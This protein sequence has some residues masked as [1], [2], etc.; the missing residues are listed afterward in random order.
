MVHDLNLFMLPFLDG[1]RHQA[2]FFMGIRAMVMLLFEN[3]QS[4]VDGFGLGMSVGVWHGVTPFGVS[5][6]KALGKQGLFS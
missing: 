5:K 6:K 1:V 2:R 4:I 3:L